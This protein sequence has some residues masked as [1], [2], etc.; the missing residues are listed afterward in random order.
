MN[1]QFARRAILSAAAVFA[2][3][4]GLRAAETGKAAPPVE[5]T[6]VSPEKFTDVTDRYA[7]GDSGRDDYLSRLKEHLQKSAAPRLAP[8]QKLAVAFT[9]IDLA[10]D[11][12]EWRGIHASDIRILREIYPPRMK[13]K[14]TLTDSTGKVVKEG[15]RE[16]IDGAYLLSKPGFSDDELRYDKKLLD[17]WLRAEF[18]RPAADN[19]GVGVGGSSPR[20]K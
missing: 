4:S 14:F 19:H 13:L 11:F 12:E 9:D 6:F 16:L 8:G 17:D 3:A 7:G 2:V 20:V 1:I 18:P 5:V 15:A 10:G